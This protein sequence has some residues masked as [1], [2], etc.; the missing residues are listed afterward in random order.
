MLWG[1]CVV[2]FNKTLMSSLRKGNYNV[3]IYIEKSFTQTG[4][5]LSMNNTRKHQKA[6]SVLHTVLHKAFFV[7]ILQ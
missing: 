4:I 5:F 7:V 2:V 3:R 6:S 1:T